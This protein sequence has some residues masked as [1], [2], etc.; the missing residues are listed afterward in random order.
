MSEELRWG[1]VWMLR[2][3]LC[4][5]LFDVRAPFF[6]SVS[7]SLTSSF[8]PLFFLNTICGLRVRSSEGLDSALSSL[9]SF[10]LHTFYTAHFFPAVVSKKK[11]QTKT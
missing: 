5:G 11:T 2:W 7:S 4:L 8:F 10:S 3:D 1:D 9:P 6:S